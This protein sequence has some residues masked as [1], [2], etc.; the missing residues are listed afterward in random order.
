MSFFDYNILTKSFNILISKLLN[1][2]YLNNY[3]FLFLL[4]I[5]LCLIVFII[6]SYYIVKMLKTSLDQ[7]N[8]FFYQFNNESQKILDKYGNSKI[9]KIY[10]IRQPFNKYIS[11]IL[12][13]LTGYQYNQRL[14]ES[15][16]YFPYHVF[17]MFEIK[18]GK[19]RK[20]LLVEKNNYINVSENFYIRNIQETLTINVNRKG[21]T[22]NSILNTTQKRMG[23]QKFFN[24]HP[25]KN[26]C[27][28]F[29]KEILVTIN[30]YNE[31]YKEFIFRDKMFQM[32]IPSDFTLHI[33]YSLSFIQN[34]FTSY[35]L[36]NK[37]LN[38]YSNL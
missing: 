17:T 34:I 21:Y 36:D 18:K 19:K 32:I 4:F 28:E 31:F 22:L 20:L 30:K 2:K 7:Y 26:N 16:D 33:G 1:S 3:I 6:V 27:H 8:L 25:Y 14:A 37:L 13:I 29:T 5:V 9:S 38:Q 23:I 24:W 12:N 15:K 35:I 11:F 10:L